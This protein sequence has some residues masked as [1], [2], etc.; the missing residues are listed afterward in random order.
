MHYDNRMVSRLQTSTIEFKHGICQRTKNKIAFIKIKLLHSQICN[1]TIINYLDKLV[2]FI[3]TYLRYMR[4][5]A[6]KSL[7]TVPNSEKTTLIWTSLSR[8][9]TVV[10]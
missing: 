8:W 5:V 1:K 2:D 3:D 9:L 4:T 10:F 7:G 6:W